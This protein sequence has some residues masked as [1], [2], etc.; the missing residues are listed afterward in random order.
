[1]GQPR[2]QNDRDSV[3]GISLKHAKVV[4]ANEGFGRSA[5]GLVH[6]GLHV[7]ID[8]LQFPDPRW[9]D[10]VVVML[11]WWCRALSSVLSGERPSVEVRF[12]EGPYLAEIGPRSAGSIH[13]KLIEAGLNRRLR[14]DAEV[15]MRV[16]IDSVIS[17]AERVLAECRERG[18][19]SEDAD[20]LADAM[21]SLERE[22]AGTAN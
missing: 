15:S 3:P 17:A 19:W 18:W 5:A 14:F 7:Q 1:M 16:L 9:T 21:K 8:T 13:L 11:G 2:D 20:E 4:L 10:F 22:K 6:A 12:M